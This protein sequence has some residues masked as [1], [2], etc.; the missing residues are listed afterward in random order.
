MKTI[1]VIAITIFC[2]VFFPFFLAET[3]SANG[4]A[5]DGW[6]LALL[7]TARAVDYLTEEEKNVILEMNK[8]RSN[9]RRYAEMYLDS[10]NHAATISALSQLSSLPPLMPSR[11]MSLAARDHTLDTGSRGLRGHTGSDGSSLSQRLNRYG[12]WG[13]AAG[14]TISYGQNTARGIVI[15]LLNSPGHRNII[16]NGRHRFTGVSIGTH[17]SYRHMCTIKYAAQYT[18][19]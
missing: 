17:T 7:D 2:V 1:K 5:A 6:D 11:G 10:R 13:V 14:E 4:P 9:P 18:E 15:Q 8:V 16:M 12:R 19:Q 3:Q